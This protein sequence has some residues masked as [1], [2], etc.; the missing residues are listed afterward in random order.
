MIFLPYCKF[1]DIFFNLISNTIYKGTPLIFFLFAF[2]ATK[3]TKFVKDATS[4][5]RWWWF[6]FRSSHTWNRFLSWRFTFNL[7]ASRF[8]QGIETTVTTSVR[9]TFSVN[10]TWKFKTNCIWFQGISLFS[11]FRSISKVIF[12]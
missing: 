4:C 9:A 12:H 5:S 1:L 3:K 2:L 6:N 10:Q 11:E 7:D 8:R